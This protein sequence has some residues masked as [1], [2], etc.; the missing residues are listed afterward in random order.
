[1]PVNKEHSVEFP[2]YFQMRAR[3]LARPFRPLLYELRG[4]KLTHDGQIESLNTMEKLVKNDYGIIAAYTHF[5]R[6]D[7]I[8]AVYAGTILPW[9]LDKKIHSP[10]ARHMYEDNEKLFKASKVIFGIS[11]TPLTIED[12]L[13][14]E[15]YKNALLGDGK[16]EHLRRTIDTISN[17]GYV[18]LSLQRGR[19]PYL[20]QPADTLSK[21]IEALDR[22]KLNKYAIIFF[23]F[24]MDGVENYS[25]V[26]DI[27]FNIKDIING[28]NKLILTVG[29][30][31]TK[32]QMMNTVQNDCKFIDQWAFNELAY[33][34]PDA[35][36]KKS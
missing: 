32:D 24:S 3:E 16:I 12:T 27:F 2:N 18:P 29:N 30:I 13:E 19:R 34:S 33:V 4:M 7:G 10:V 9:F 8:V 23:G 20:G 21:T 6:E 14:Y 15:E 26:K 1:M 31:F 17:G 5:C 35:Y 11:S 36:L 22:K 28:K 25:T